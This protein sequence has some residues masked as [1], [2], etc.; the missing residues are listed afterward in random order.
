MQSFNPLVDSFDDLSDSEISQKINDLQKKYFMSRNPQVQSQIAS[1][2]DMYREEAKARQQKAY[3][4]MNQNNDD[5]DLD[6]L[7]NIS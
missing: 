6:S 2:L 5:S 1:I 4:K 3:T 7:I